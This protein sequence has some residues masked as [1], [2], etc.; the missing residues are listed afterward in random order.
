M[1]I[2]ENDNWIFWLTV[3]VRSEIFLKTF[4]KLKILKTQ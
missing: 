1:E 3:I 4:Q 2:F